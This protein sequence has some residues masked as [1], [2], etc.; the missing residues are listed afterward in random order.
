MPSSP[1]AVLALQRAAGNQAVGR[2][3][4]ARGLARD[5]VAA[6]PAGGTVGT[7]LMEANRDK[8]ET[9]R[10]EALV[11]MGRLTKLEGSS[12]DAINAAKTR[13][14]ETSTE[15][16]RAYENYARVIQAAKLEAANQQFYADIVMGIAIAVLVGVTVE[17][18]PIM[19]GCAA[20]AEA[21]GVG[22]K[23]AGKAA[24]KTA[25]KDAVM[26]GAEIIVGKAAAAT[27]LAV[28]GTDLEPGGMRPEILK[29]GVWKSLSQL[30]QNAPRIGGASLTQGLLMSNAE[31]AI[32][33]IK[34]HTGGGKGD[35][36]E[37]D[38]I[39]LI[40]TV[41]KAGDAAKDVDKKL[42]AAEAKIEA[43]RKAA[44]TPVTYKAPQMERDIWNLWMGSLKEDSNILDIDAIEDYLG[45]KGLKMVDFGDYTS[46]DDENEAILK[47]R[48]SKKEIE[49][50]RK[51]GMSVGGADPTG[52]AE[53]EMPGSTNAPRTPGTPRE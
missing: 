29:M 40:L 23:A 13:M 21:V 47:A 24:V 11:R 33:E 15:Y 14:L 25:G 26:E 32:G 2:M 34:A 49:D 30:H 39:D 46:D 19:L 36:G 45:P 16:D 41:I 53:G 3:L 18:V 50:R 9:I 35:M 48:G 28:A 4:S 10:A 5:P 51:A 7:A 8:L 17:A 42:D 44:S 52:A 37:Q 31:Y 12:R 43:L 38:A 20:A 6:P 22:L 1:G 27:G